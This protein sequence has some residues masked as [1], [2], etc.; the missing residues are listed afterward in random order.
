MVVTLRLFG[1]EEQLKRSFQLESVA[2]A[3]DQV[4]HALCEVFVAE[5]VAEV[6]LD[7]ICPGDCGVGALVDDAGVFHFASM[8]IEVHLGDE[9]FVVTFF[10]AELVA[11]RAALGLAAGL[12]SGSAK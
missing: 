8:T 2:G 7:V 10:G 4:L 11:E 3:F 5:A 6:N 9:V 1:F 12:G